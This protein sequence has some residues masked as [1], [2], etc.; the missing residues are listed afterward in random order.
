MARARDGGLGELL[1]ERVHGRGHAMLRQRGAN[2]SGSDHWRLHGVGERHDLSR[3][4]QRGRL[5]QGLFSG[6]DDRQQ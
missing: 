4:L 5:C 1:H 2:V 3:R 6:L